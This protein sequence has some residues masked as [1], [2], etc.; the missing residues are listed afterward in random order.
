MIIPNNDGTDV[1]AKTP[2]VQEQ[3]TSLPATFSTL[4]GNKN[5]TDNAAVESPLIPS[6]IGAKNGF[7]FP[8]IRK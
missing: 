7:N 1:T 2:Q 6:Q 3:T 4:T 5:H 8:L